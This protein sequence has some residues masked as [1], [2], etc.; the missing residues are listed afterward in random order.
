MR[1]EW[2]ES[3]SQENLKKHMVSFERAC[4]AFE[5]LYCLSVPDEYEFE[6]RW[7]TMGLVNGAVILLVVHTI[8]E[9]DNEEI[10]RIISARKAT[11]REAGIYEKS[12]QN[13]K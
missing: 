2:D 9:E 7:Q 6:E 1:F 12:R 8:R 13:G 4:L 5:D 11:S 3:K 10:V